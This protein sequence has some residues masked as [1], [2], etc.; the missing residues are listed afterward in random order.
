MD[1]HRETGIDRNTIR[2]ISRRE[3]VKAGTLHR[4]INFIDEGKKPK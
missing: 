4:V 1:L 2:S 3:P